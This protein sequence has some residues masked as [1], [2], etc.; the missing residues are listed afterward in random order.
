MKTVLIAH[1]Y[2]QTSFAAMSYFLANHLCN[3][4][5]RVVF[6]S[7]R[8][9]LNQSEKRKI[10]KGELILCSWPNNFRSTSWSDFVFFYKLSKKYKPQVVIGHHNGTITSVITSK[11]LFGKNVLT[12]DYHHVCTE[13]YLL[14]NLGPDWRVKFF[15]FRKKILYNFFCDMVICPSTKAIEDVTNKFKHKNPVLIYNPLPDRLT[16]NQSPAI[17]GNIT[18]GYLGRL[19]PCKNIIW[20]IEQFLVYESYNPQT[21]IKLKIAGEGFLKEELQE[22]IKKSNR[23]IYLGEISYEEVD[24]FIQSAH[25][26]ITPSLADNAPTVVTESLMLSTPPILSNRVGTAN[27]FSNMGNAFLFS[28]SDSEGLFQVF[29]KIETISNFEYKSLCSEA[30]KLYLKHFTMDKYFNHVN[31]II[32]DEKFKNDKSHVSP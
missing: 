23:I 20:L 10:G 5:Y 17:E 14:D 6:I 2:E 9:Y 28:P 7:K 30:R 1:N 26:T 18:I 13:S 27:L 22:K 32:L 12:A 21:K 25:F 15:L 24:E 16:T 31:S 29:R 19:I 4:G 11:L 3:Q 8:P